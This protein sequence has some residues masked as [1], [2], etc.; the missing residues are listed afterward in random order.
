VARDDPKRAAR[1]RVN[2]VVFMCV[3]FNGRK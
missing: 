3:P 1:E 2:S